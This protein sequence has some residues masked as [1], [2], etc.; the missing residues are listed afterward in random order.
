MKCPFGSEAARLRSVPRPANRRQLAG[1]PYSRAP[2]IGSQTAG[3]KTGRRRERRRPSA[4]RR[5]SRNAQRPFLTSLC[6]TAMA[7]TA[8]RLSQV[9]EIKGRKKSWSA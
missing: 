4:S 7:H 3:T 8:E 5:T 6:H 2:R 1:K 9:I